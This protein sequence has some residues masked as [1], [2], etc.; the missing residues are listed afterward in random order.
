M[1]RRPPRSTQSRSS[2]ASDVYKRQVT[3][4]LTGSWIGEGSANW[5]SIIRSILRTA[6]GVQPVTMSFPT[7]RGVPFTLPWRHA[8]FVTVGCTVPKGNLLRLDA[9]YATP[10]TLPKLLRR[11]QPRIGFWLLALKKQST[12]GRLWTDH[13]SAECAM[14]MS[15]A[16]SAT[17]F[18]CLT[19]RTGQGL[20]IGKRTHR[21]VRPAP[22]AIRTL[23]SAMTVTM[24][25][26]RSFLIGGRVLGPQNGVTALIPVMNVIQCRHAI[27][28]PY[29]PPANQEAPCTPHGDSHCRRKGP[30]GTWSRPHVPVRPF[31]DV[32]PLSS[33]WGEA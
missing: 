30:N 11:M 12:V 21:N 26:T 29:D 23:P 4:D 10:Q 33:P 13:C 22:C 14:K 7:D 32:K 16:S 2:A 15:L 25:G 17:G 18:S 8:S 3:T 19:P 20:H 9:T 31:P 1:I 5:S 6:S 28:W 27:L 24:R